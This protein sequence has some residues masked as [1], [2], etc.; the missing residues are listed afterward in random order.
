[1]NDNVNSEK[2]NDLKN[3]T[4][5]YYQKVAKETIEISILGYK[6]NEGK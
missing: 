3:K 2:V 1:M 6:E 5:N 4:I